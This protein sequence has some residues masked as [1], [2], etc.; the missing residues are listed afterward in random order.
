MFNLNRDVPWFFQY[1]ENYY[2]L[3]LNVRFNNGTDTKKSIDFLV[4]LGLQGF[5]GLIFY[6]YKPDLKKIKFDLYK[7]SI[8]QTHK[9]S[10]LNFTLN[11]KSINTLDF[12]I[13]PF[14]YFKDEHKF[15]LDIRSKELESSFDIYAWAPSNLYRHIKSVIKIDNK[16]SELIPLDDYKGYYFQFQSSFKGN[17]TG[18]LFDLINLLVDL[19]KTLDELD[20]TPIFEPMDSEIKSLISKSNEFLFEL[21]QTSVPLDVK[22][23]V[24]ELER[25]KFNIDN[26][27]KEEIFNWLDDLIDFYSEK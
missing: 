15:N 27:T 9:I 8:D 23:I 20:N 3:F 2:H 12:V 14:G 24:R 21:C 1:L 26:L 22:N 7:H 6:M 25:L 17:E 13:I 10:D 18:R 5:E 16:Y 11:N 19:D 4:E